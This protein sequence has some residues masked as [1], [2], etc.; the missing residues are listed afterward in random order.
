MFQQQYISFRKV[1]VLKTERISNLS[2][3]H[4]SDLDLTLY[5]RGMRFCLLA[6]EKQLK[7]SLWAVGYCGRKGSHIS[8]SLNRTFIKQ[9]TFK[10]QRQNQTLV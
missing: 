1:Y 7:M 9:L 2:V 8:D 5:V 6:G 4:M 3:P 10:S